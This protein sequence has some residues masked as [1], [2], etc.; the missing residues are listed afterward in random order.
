MP[1]IARRRRPPEAGTPGRNAV[2]VVEADQPRAVRRV[3]RERVGQAVRSLPG[4]LDA[5]DLE[6]DPVALF[7]VVDARVESQQ[8]L[9]GVF[10]FPTDIDISCHDMI[11]VASL[12]VKCR[13]R[14]AKH[15]SRN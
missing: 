1:V 5:L 12:P 11:Y 3:Q 10:R 6:L 13:L 15:E 2:G 9:E 14:S 7:E 4:R 8:K